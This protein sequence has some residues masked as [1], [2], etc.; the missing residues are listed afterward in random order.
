MKGPKHALFLCVLITA[1]LPN[2]P[3]AA[4]Q[5]RERQEQSSPS[6]RPGMEPPLGLGYSSLA[7]GLAL[8]CW[9]GISRRFWVQKHFKY[10][11]NASQSAIRVVF[12]CCWR[13]KS[14]LPSSELYGGGHCT[15]EPKD[16]M[17]Q[18]A[19]RALP[20]FHRIPFSCPWSP[21]LSGMLQITAS[22][23]LL[24][25]R[26]R[27]WGMGEADRDHFQHSIIPG[28]I[29]MALLVT[30]GQ[31]AVRFPFLLGSRRRWSPPGSA[32]QRFYLSLSG[33]RAHR[34]VT[35]Y[36]LGW[37]ISE[38]TIKRRMKDIE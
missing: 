10:R 18:E 33:P 11:L 13:Q 21:A 3:T 2:G 4:V 24:I 6:Q 25:F 27:Y 31:E 19:K 14:R 8:F 5:N 20:G 29:N 1:I 22:L 34:D 32:S 23:D 16:C 38:L 17:L 15:P 28:C 7:C 36:S 37:N 12:C 30:R 9:L 35:A 26:I